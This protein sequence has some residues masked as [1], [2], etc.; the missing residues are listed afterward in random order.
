MSVSTC[1]NVALHVFRTEA[2]DAAACHGGGCTAV[3]APLLPAQPHLHSTAST[4]SI[5][6]GPHPT[7]SLT[8][9]SKAFSVKCALCSSSSVGTTFRSGLST[10]ATCH[11]HQQ[12][13]VRTSLA[14]TSGS[15]S[16]T[17]YGKQAHQLATLHYQGT[18][19]AAAVCHGLA[20]T[21]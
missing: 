16:D 12:W 3:L 17:E 19:Y 4:P 5:S 13:Q 18:C 1:P 8:M 10:V 14:H 2:A 6:A 15:C 9:W 20:N 11:Q 7:C 21:V